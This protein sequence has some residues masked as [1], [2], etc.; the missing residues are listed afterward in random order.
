MTTPIIS[1]QDHLLFLIPQSLFC[2]SY[3][4]KFMK[5]HVKFH[6]GLFIHMCKTKR[7]LL[8]PSPGKMSGV[9]VKLSFHMLKF[10]FAHESVQ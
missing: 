4:L 9:H 3:M 2:S 5:Q 10:K 1:P 8:G 6:G 7:P